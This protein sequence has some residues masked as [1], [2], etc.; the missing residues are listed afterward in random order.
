MIEVHA[1]WGKLRVS[2]DIEEIPSDALRYLYVHIMNEADIR[3]THEDS[4]KI[5][6]WLKDREKI[7]DKEPG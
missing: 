4:E 3:I 5:G 6:Q 7:N 2:V 1:N